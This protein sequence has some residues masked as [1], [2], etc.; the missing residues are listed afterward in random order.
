[1]ANS[2]LRDALRV[3][4][5]QIAKRSTSATVDQW[6]SD[7]LALVD[8]V[9]DEII[10]R[11]S[12]HERRQGKDQVNPGRRGGQRRGVKQIHPDTPV[13]GTVNVTSQAPASMEP[14]DTYQLVVQ[15]LSTEGALL[16][17]RTVTYT[18]TVEAD[19]T[20]SVGGLVTAVSDGSSVVKA[21][22]EGVS[23]AGQT[24]TVTTPQGPLASVTVTPATGALGVTQ[25]Q[26][27]QAIPRDAS[28][29]F[30]PGLTVTWGTSS[31]AI[32][33]VSADSG[34]DNHTATVTA[35]GA[36]VATI[37]ATCGAFTD[38]YVATVT[39]AGAFAWMTPINPL[40]TGLTP[41]YFNRLCQEVRIGARDNEWAA[42]GGDLRENPT[43]DPDEAKA[44]L[45][46]LGEGTLRQQEEGYG[47]LVQAGAGLAFPS[48]NPAVH[49]APWHEPPAEDALVLGMDWGIA[50]PSVVTAYRVGPQKTL[51]A[52]REWSWQDKD[53]YEAGWDFAH[54]LLNE[55]F[56]RWP[57]WLVVDSAMNE[58]TGTGGT[59]ILMEFQAGVDDGLRTTNTPP[60]HI[61]PA[62]KGPGSRAAGFN[63]VTKVLG[64]GPALADGTVPAS[65]MPLFRIMR[66]RQG[67]VSCPLLAKD[68]ATA[69]LDPKKKNDVDKTRCGFHAGD[70][71]Y[72]TLSIVLPNAD[73][74]P[75]VVPVDRHP[76]W[77]PNGQRRSRE[78]TPEVLREERR[79]VLEHQAAQSGERLGGRYGRNPRT[80]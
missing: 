39:A 20:V 32:A 40:P 6:C 24:I 51:L 49:L 18:S 45:K 44:Y 60:L 56:L 16:T 7:G 43:I 63:Q 80:L 50:S 23:S 34:D 59:T 66:D 15:V 57:D 77:L 30:L 37:T 35:V 2:E 64:W 69:P 41:S 13:V 26:Q 5:A 78:R 72:Y 65:R 54:S 70:G 27:V 38:T 55:P 11:R 68:L 12:G 67:E 22:C 33:T 21:H 74:V 8:Q 4:L 76:G 14:S 53:A 48:W 19:A 25:T 42:F 75:E 46:G 61:L 31:G 52:V 79:I 10:E 9:A 3:L 73:T 36:G 17:G 62:P 71:L 58:R 1:L 29:N 28:A 47:L